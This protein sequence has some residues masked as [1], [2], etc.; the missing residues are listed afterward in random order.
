MRILLTGATGYIGKRLLPVLIENGHHVICGVR[1]KTRFNPPKSLKANIS[2]VEIDLLKKE[3]LKEIPFDIDAAYYL[4]HS[5]SGSK[6]YKD[7]EKK[8]A[9]NFRESIQ[10]T[11]VKQVIY[12]SGIVNESNLS[13]HLLSR[14]TVEDELQKGTYSFTCLRAAIIIG[15][16]SASFEIMRDLVEKLPVM[17]TPKWLQTK[18][19]PI[20]VSD[21]LAFLSG[22]LL[23]ELTFDR[24]FDIGGPDIISY[25][26]MLLGF[27]EMRN[28]KRYIWTVPV[29]TPRL[30]SYWLYFVTSTSFKLASSLVDSMKV[31][32]VCRNTELNDLLGIVPI[33]Y[34]E[35]LRR[36]FNKI[37]NNEI[38]SSWKDSYVS[39]GIRPNISEFINVPIHG[40]YTDE[41]KSNINDL[42][43]TIEKIWSIGGD[44]GWY[45][46][47]WLW[48]L[49][50]FLDKLV[51][52]VG[53][54]RGRTNQNTIS[55]GDALDFWR[56]LYADKSEGR[57]LLFAE[58]KLPG[59]A[60]LEFRVEENDLIQIATFRP[61]GLLGRLY[62]YA[63]FPFHGFIFNGLIK[64]LTKK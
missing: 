3:T 42:E 13:E 21:V 11:S 33:S 45:S 31:E 37:Q 38:L 35:A 40:C 9:I 51:G 46:G 48:K 62:W 28:L 1:D 50:G 43:G 27:A 49:R 63:V 17:I 30:S 55:V 24:D 2:I 15:S 7:L 32:V 20:G 19:Q 12:L 44:N 64:R 39:S 54:R 36:A 59:E 58:M 16:G 4:V 56:V 52:G 18:S 22:S 29:M 26:K 5:M 41:K 47:N 10:S 57:L 6:A 61:L 14:K 53:L 23:N 60:W 25:R 34:K 8:S